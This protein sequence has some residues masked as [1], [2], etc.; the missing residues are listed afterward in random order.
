MRLWLALTLALLGL[1][2]LGA[3]WIGLSPPEPRVVEIERVLPADRFAP[4]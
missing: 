1:V 2:A 3:V 4:R